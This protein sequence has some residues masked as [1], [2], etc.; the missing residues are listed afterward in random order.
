MKK[1]CAIVAIFSII[2]YAIA[3]EK[4][5]F[6]G[7]QTTYGEQYKSFDSAFSKWFEDKN[8]IWLVLGN[9]GAKNYYRERFSK[10][11]IF[12]DY[13]SSSDSIGISG[14]FL[15]PNNWKQVSKILPKKVNYIAV[16]FNDLVDYSKRNDIIRASK[17]ILGSDGMFCVEDEYDNRKKQFK[18]FT[19]EDLSKLS[20]DFDIECA[21]WDGYIS[22]LPYSSYQSANKK[23]DIYKGLEMMILRL[24]SADAR[25][26]RKLLPYITS[27]LYSRS[28]LIKK[29]LI[30]RLVR[31]IVDSTQLRQLIRKYEDALKEE[32]RLNDIIEKEKREIEEI[33]K[34][35]ENYT[36]ITNFSGDL[37]NKFKSLSQKV[38]ALT[39][40]VDYLNDIQH[41]KNFSF[42]NKVSKFLDKSDDGTKSLQEKLNEKKNKLS[43]HKRTLTALQSQ[44]DMTKADIKDVSDKILKYNE[45]IFAR[46]ERDKYLKPYVKYKKTELDDIISDSKDANED[47]WDEYD[48]FWSSI[49]ETEILAKELEKS[50]SPDV[51]VQNLVPIEKIRSDAEQKMTN[52]SR[53][54]ILFIKKEYPPATIESVILKQ[55]P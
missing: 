11:W 1:S 24:A 8:D 26:K 35:I 12:W 5:H 16:D 18:H 41:R 37:S 3:T 36:K 49:S 6:S 15:D 54:L 31:D 30:K 25:E 50:W 20:Q 55:I 34:D 14:D 10:N 23:S 46:F 40:G 9:R 22:A 42:M 43:V 28:F 21:Y 19:D 44:L 47:F 39:K 2:L 52:T 38:N 32:V 45:E 13:H 27:D 17:N 29:D 33:K 7:V 4:E 51:I 48:S 53:V